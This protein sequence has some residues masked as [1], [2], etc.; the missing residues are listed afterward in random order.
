MC[1]L[2]LWVCWTFKVTSPCSSVSEEGNSVRWSVSQT[3]QVTDRTTADS[4]WTCGSTHSQ[5]NHTSLIHTAL[6]RQFSFASP[7]IDFQNI[8]NNLRQTELL[9]HVAGSSAL[10]DVNYPAT[11]DSNTPENSSELSDFPYFAD[12]SL[13]NA[14]LP[15]FPQAE[16]SLPAHLL[17]IKLGERKRD[18]P[19][20]RSMNTLS[21]VAIICSKRKE[22]VLET[23]LRL[24]RA[25]GILNRTVEGNP[26][27]G[28]WK[29]QDV[30]PHGV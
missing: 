7:T 17:Y 11:N 25:A 3:G 16:E 24:C 22:V 8:F 23:S 20:E 4:Y 14:N 28:E 10:N 26:Q 30:S 9:R 5:W 15:L 21:Q 12:L 27:G 29:L 1:Q 18:I 19:Q 13:L 6:C 2:D